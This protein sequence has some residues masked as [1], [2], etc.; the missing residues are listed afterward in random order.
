[1]HEK[2]KIKGHKVAE[3]SPVGSNRLT[4]NGGNVQETDNFQAWDERVKN[5]KIWSYN[6]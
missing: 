2:S 1:M 4:V 5:G 6:K 3:G